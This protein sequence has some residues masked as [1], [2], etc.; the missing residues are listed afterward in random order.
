MRRRGLRWGEGHALRVNRLY[1]DAGYLTVTSSI[2][3]GPLGESVEGE[4]KSRRGTV[5]TSAPRQAPGRPHQGAGS[6]AG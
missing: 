4:P 2:T 5:D 3:R 6:R 1:L